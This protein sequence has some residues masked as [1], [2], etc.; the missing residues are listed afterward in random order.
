M[1]DIA[2][3]LFDIAGR[4]LVT[5]G[6]I[7]NNKR[8]NMSEV[9][10]L[11]DPSL[12]CDPW[13]DYPI[14]IYGAVGGLTDDEYLIICG[15]YDGN[16]TQKLCYMMNQTGTREIQ[17]M[18]TDLHYSAGAPFNNILLISGGWSTIQGVLYFS[19]VCS[20]NLKMTILS[21]NSLKGT[22]FV[23]INDEVYGPDSP[24][25]V[26]HHCI[27]A[28]NETTMISI[29]GT[30]DKLSYVRYKT[31]MYFDHQSQE[32]TIGPEMNLKRFRHACGKLVVG[33]ASI[34][35]VAGGYTNNEYHTSK[36]VEFLLANDTW[37]EGKNISITMMMDVFQYEKFIRT[38]FAI[39]AFRKRTYSV[40]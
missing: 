31:T 24:F 19:L 21:D 28:I 37:V 18:K 9:V 35:V 6:G 10:D 2:L 14:E 7:G 5:T 36:S 15:G 1:V 33:N 16:Q 34:I 32:W 27:T 4:L 29:G 26:Y 23:S 25:L 39:G 8:T 3:Q 22:E 30:R 11:S 12:I 20:S 13:P 17:G 40:S 38:E